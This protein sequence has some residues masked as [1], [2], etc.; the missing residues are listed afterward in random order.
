[1]CVP[2]AGIPSRPPVRIWRGQDN[3]IRKT[4]YPVRFPQCAR[5]PNSVRSNALRSTSLLH[6]KAWQPVALH[7][8]VT[9]QP[10]SYR[11]SSR[12]ELRYPGSPQP[13][14][15]YAVSSPLP[16][17]DVLVVPHDEAYESAKRHQLQIAPS[18]EA[19]GPI[20][21]ILQ[22]DCAARLMTCHRTRLASCSGSAR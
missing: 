3:S 7:I 15:P 21:H 11:P 2:T 10:L 14:L 18:L 5:M 17:A 6:P 16:A 22:C 1:M 20:R 8:S 12:G 13:Q 19:F 4:T 9:V